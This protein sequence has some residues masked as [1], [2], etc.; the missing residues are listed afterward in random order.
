MTSSERSQYADGYALA[1]EDVAKW[2]TDNA[3]E[4]LGGTESD[5]PLCMYDRD[6]SVFEALAARLRDKKPLIDGRQEGGRTEKDAVEWTDRNVLL[7]DHDAERFGPCTEWTTTISGVL[8]LI[9]HEVGNSA[10]F[11]S[12]SYGGRHWESWSYD[13]DEVSTDKATIENIARALIESES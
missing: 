4:A 2:L 7:G 5:P 9:R 11:T 8:L 1:L 13:A 6:G 3:W 12:V 10:L